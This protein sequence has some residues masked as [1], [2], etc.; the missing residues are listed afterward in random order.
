MF[1]SFPPQPWPSGG[2][3]PA[4]VWR[5]SGSQSKGACFTQ[6]LGVK[7]WGSLCLKMWALKEHVLIIH[8]YSSYHM[9]FLYDWLKMIY[10]SY[11]VDIL[12][13]DNSWYMIFPGDS[14]WD[15]IWYDMMIRNPMIN[16]WWSLTVT[17]TLK[18]APDTFWGSSPY[19]WLI[20]SLEK[21]SETWMKSP[22]LVFWSVIAII[23][24]H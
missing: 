16:K 8:Q 21:K 11:M 3:F 10:M 14:Q 23:N 24:Q 1:Q 7:W 22:F 12:F 17:V 13:I 15:M 2:S 20:E 5:P 18:T 6:F 4:A 9:W 19:Y